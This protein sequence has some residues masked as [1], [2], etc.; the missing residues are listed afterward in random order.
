MLREGLRLGLVV[1]VVAWLVGA[2]PWVLFLFVAGFVPGL[3]WST[4]AWEADEVDGR[5][6]LVVAFVAALFVA[7]LPWVRWDLGLAPALW[8][9]TQLARVRVIP[10]R[11]DTIDPEVWAS[12]NAH[13]YG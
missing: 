4:R 8:L 9:G 2:L 11:V 6:S 3:W 5:A 13:R 7:I 10:G 1:A 12:L